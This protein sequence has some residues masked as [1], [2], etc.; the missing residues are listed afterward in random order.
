MTDEN[1][2]PLGSPF[3][4]FKSVLAGGCPANSLAIFCSFTSTS[5]RN[6]FA[7]IRDL[8]KLGIVLH[9]E[10]EQHLPDPKESDSVEKP[11]KNKPKGPQPHRKFGLD[12]KL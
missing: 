5:K 3:D 10:N 8:P 9:L 7:N 6:I 2:I 4:Q 12:K 1:K 11:K